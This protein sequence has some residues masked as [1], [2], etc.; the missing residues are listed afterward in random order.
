MSR[1]EGEHVVPST[2]SPSPRPTFDGPTLI[3][4]RDVTRHLW[5]DEASGYVTD[6]IY[7]STD[8]IHQLV[9]GLPP[10]G[11][12]KHSDGFRT[13]FAADQVFLVLSGSVAF[14]NPETGEAHVVHPGEVA[15]FSRDTWHHGLNCSSEPLRVLEFFAPPPSQGTSGAYARTRPLLEET[16]RGQDEWIGSWPASK[17]KATDGFTMRV[18]RDADV[19]WR[20]EGGTD[21][22]AVLTGLWVST[23]LLTVGSTRVLPGQR[24]SAFVHAGD[25]GLYVR[26]GT[27]CIGAHGG[28]GLRWHE[29]V[30]GDGF[31]VPEG[32]AH[33]FHN[34]SDEPADVAFGVAPGYLP[35]G[36]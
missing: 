22:D 31:Y 2:Y 36:G 27:L 20:L 33:R 4:R 24:S 29:L 18:L 26:R 35:L 9:F 34:V 28:E 14:S 7:V 10:G 25:K 5:G 23:E 30:E 12:F 8:K 32:V 16:K 13:V 3:P 15:C 21:G 17:E 1:D 19:L 6:W 11:A